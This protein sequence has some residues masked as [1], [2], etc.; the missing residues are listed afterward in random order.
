VKKKSTLAQEVLVLHGVKITHPDRIVFED[1]NVTKGDVARYYAGVAPLLLR[2]ITRRPITVVRCPS[3]VKANCFYQRNVGFGLGED[4]HPFFWNYKGS[5]Y[6]YIYVKDLKGIM[7]MIQMGVIEIHPWGA[8][9]DKIHTPDRM[10]IDLD[11]DPSVPFSEVKKAALETRTRLKKAG[12]ESMLKCTGGK[13]LHLVVP[14]APRSSWEDV[15]A[16]ASSLAHQMV[17]D[18][19]DT[20]VAT[21]TKSKRKGK[22]LIDF[23]RNDYTA[24]AIAGYSLRARAGAPV[25][26]PLDWHELTTLDGADQFD[27]ETVLKRIQT[28]RGQKILPPQRLPTVSMERMDRGRTNQH[29]PDGSAA[30]R[31]LTRRQRMAV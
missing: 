23:F 18:A 17:A 12:L 27:M 19:P 4:V 14:L 22:I 21:I 2:E 25:A 10:I 7:E 29:L 15:K 30:R 11:P 16:W 13:G 6:K 26:V 3:G 8:R 9:I 1:G 31:T 28:R 24:T 5:S 20:Y